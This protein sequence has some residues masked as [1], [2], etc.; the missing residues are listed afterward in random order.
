MAMGNDT[1]G[2]KWGKIIDQNKCIGC[3]AC[4]VACKQEHSVP[5]GVTRTYVKQVEV[6]TFPDS[7]HEFQITRCNQCNEPPC[8][9][10]C[11]TTAMYRR[12]DGIVDFDRDICI[13]CKACIAACPYD[14][15]YI[16]PESHS[17][18]KCN[19]CTNRIDIGLEPACV[20][21]CPTQ[22]IL[23]GDMND[24]SSKV[25]Q[26]LD[27]QQVEVRRPEKKTIPKLFYVG[28][29]GHTLDPQSASNPQGAS[30]PG[31]LPWAQSQ[32]G[33]LPGGTLIDPSKRKRSGD[34]DQSAAAAILVYDQPHRIPWDWR[35]SSYT[36]TK[37]IAS[38]AFLMTAILGIL[39]I[40][41]SQRWDVITTILSAAFLGLTGLLLVSDLS[42][43]RRFY[44]VLIRHQWRSWLV[45]GAYIISAYTLLLLVFFIAALA[46][47]RDLIQVLRW[48]GIVTSILV[49][50]YTAFLLG[51]SKGRDLW[52]NPLLILA[53]LSHAVVAGSASLLILSSIVDLPEGGITRLQWALLISAAAFLALA[54][55]DLINPHPTSQ[56]EAAA[57]NMLWGK[58][59]L[60]YWAGIFLGGIV[61]LVLTA[62]ALAGSPDWTYIAASASALTGLLAYEH[63]YIQAGQSVPQ[64]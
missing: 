19:F 38:G 11:P 40:S 4:T 37:S 25:S 15:I 22:A 49:A 6:G 32:S 48:I 2:I 28:A 29:S 3:H 18:E 33:A 45:R 39:D 20:V 63:A 46:E 35:V 36:W 55:S 9:A 62:M 30:A 10:A 56:A 42:H 58:Y 61:P 26:I 43:P 13:G 41:L 24:P 54:L 8:V 17:A 51:Q 47:W 31:R 64:S 21:V 60:H 16:D 57:R 1:Q 59:R 44:Y 23:V 34:P 50:V 14:A 12:P 52:Q 53:F 27:R 7:R 5:L